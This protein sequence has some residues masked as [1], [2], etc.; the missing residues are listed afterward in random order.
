ME[1]TKTA[2]EILE[3]YPELEYDDVVSAM[4]EYASI[5]IEEQLK[6][7]A[8]EATVEVV[9]SE[10]LDIRSLPP[11]DGSTVILPIYGVD[12]DTILNCTRVKLD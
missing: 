11:H 10:E 3:K 7:A 1:N 4:K 5:K 12:E 8:R 9:D 6:I 2:E